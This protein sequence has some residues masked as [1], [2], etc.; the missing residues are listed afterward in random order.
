MHD[1][2]IRSIDINSP[3]RRANKKAAALKERRGLSG[4]AWLA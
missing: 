3:V 2:G 1:H 4:A